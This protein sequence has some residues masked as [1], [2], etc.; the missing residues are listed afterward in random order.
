MGFLN[1]AAWLFAPLIAVLIALYLW[2]QQRRRVDVPSL[3]LWEDVPEAVIRTSRFRPDLLF[4]LQ[5]LLLSLLI[6]GFARPYLSAGNHT[7]AGQR[8]I[9]VL[10]TSASMQAH[11][12][13]GNRFD[14]ARDALLKRI[15]NLSAADEAMLISAASY[16]RTI[17]PFSH[18]HAAL[19][20]H[21][22]ALQ[23]VD[24]GTQLEPALALARRAAT[25]EDRPTRIE[26]F[27]D[28]APSLLPAEWRDDVTVFQVGRSDDN[29][30][31]EGFEI[32]QGR[33]QDPGEASARV[34]IRNFSRRD[35]HGF[36]SIRL[37]GDIISRRGFSLDA[38]EIQTFPLHHFP[39]A[40]VVHATLEVEDALA[41]DNHAYG[42]VRPL[43]PIELVVVSDTSALRADLERIAQSVP[44][45]SLRF[46]SPDEYE[47]Q[48]TLFANA[49]LFEGY[50]PATLPSHPSLYVFPRHSSPW[51]SVM[52]SE[53]RLPVLNWNER[54][55]ALG[56]L[57][58]QLVF[59]LSDVR[60]VQLPDWA[61][62]LLSSS[63][64]GREVPLAF[65][66]E[67]NGQ[68]LAGLSF[69]LAAE[70]L[71]SADN[72]NLLLLF[73]NL[74]DWLL[75]ADSQILIRH[76]GEVY[77]LQGRPDQ[78]RRVVDP[79][80][81]VTVSPPGESLRVELLHAGEYRVGTDHDQHRL[82]ANFVDPI[83][84]DIGRDAPEASI[85]RQPGTGTSPA[86]SG[87]APFD[88]WLYT[89]AAVLFLVEW[90]VAVR[91]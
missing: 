55:P 60:I 66:G 31:I 83:E 65:A 15:S 63:W 7:E 34:T 47:G 4:F 24:D 89:L 6:V 41:V 90:I 39:H 28:V 54:H 14:E 3:L 35:K 21:V 26:L 73:V 20:R 12:T 48:P 81:Q 59:P 19:A 23:P 2:E 72:V 43:Q 18:D 11:E 68:R 22:R 51:F 32:F 78:I 9:F 5:L 77:T 30:A 69:D 87:K 76:T 25:R 8:Y 56:N 46:L 86:A 71:L 40:G 91:T 50:V 1:S 74:I 17:V 33:F 27:T 44:N 84:S 75:P 52:G 79:S 45:L 58:P 42:W 88:A 53:H 80:G 82:Y 61:D 70:S 36:L 85:D 49:T 10:D 13:P 16:P 67:H 62:T 37:G 64:R 29:L 57:R 38:G